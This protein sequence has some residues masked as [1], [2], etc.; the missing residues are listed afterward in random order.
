MVMFG[1]QVLPVLGELNAAFG[2]VQPTVTAEHCGA[3]EPGQ[4]LGP[5]LASVLH[6]SL[7]ELTGLLAAYVGAMPPAIQETL[8][9]VIHYA[10]TSSPQV[11]LNFSWTPG[12]E[13]EVTICEIVEPAPMQ[14]GVSILLKS[15]YPNEIAA[16][17]P[18]S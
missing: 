10:L 7:G 11:L 9:S 18:A 14:S 15:R 3:F 1:Q 17:A 13:F 16:L 2:G 12:Y 8:R 6:P 4:C 5:A